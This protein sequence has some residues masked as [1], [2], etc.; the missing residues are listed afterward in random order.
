MKEINTSHFMA[1]VAKDAILREHGQA[2]HWPSHNFWAM[3]ST[4]KEAIPEEH[5]PALLKKYNLTNLADYSTDDGRL[6]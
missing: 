4:V 2:I 6:L 5:M 3:V 1:R